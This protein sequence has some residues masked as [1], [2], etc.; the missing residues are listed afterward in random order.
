MKDAAGGG[1]N[2]YNALKPYY[3][4]EYQMQNDKRMFKSLNLVYRQ[5]KPTNFEHI[6]YKSDLVECQC[7]FNHIDEALEFVRYLIVKG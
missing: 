4:I 6:S 3:V 7:S 1:I 2:I 5:S